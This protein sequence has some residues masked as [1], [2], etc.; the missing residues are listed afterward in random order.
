MALGSSLVYVIFAAGVTILVRQRAV[1]RDA[2]HGVLLDEAGEVRGVHGL[3]LGQVARELVHQRP[4]AHQQVLGRVVGL[5]HDAPYLL[6]DLEGDLVGVVRLGVEVPAHEHLPVGVPQGHRPEL[7][8]HAV[9]RDHL[10]G[11]LRYALEVVRRPR[12]DLVEDHALCRPAAEHHRQLRHELAAAHH[13]PVLGGQAHRHPQGLAAGDDADLV[14]RVGVGQQS[15][16]DGVTGLVVGG[17]LLLLVGDEPGLA[18]RTGYDPVYGL[19]HLDLVYLVLVV[20][21]GEQRRLV[22]EV[23]EVRAGEAGRAAGQRLYVDIRAEG[24]A[25]RVDAQDLLAPRKVGPVNDDLAVEAA[26]AQEGR[27]EDVRAVGGGDHDDPA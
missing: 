20:P 9:P 24:L 26:R 1:R 14:D 7:L 15:T 16:H 3:V 25:P 2:V 22:D 8:A 17:D 6:V 12:G 21:R 27:V 18:L 4:V 11:R 5:V 19:L 10:L 23:R 13:E